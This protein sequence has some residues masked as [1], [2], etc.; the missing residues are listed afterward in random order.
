[1]KCVINLTFQFFFIYLMI[2]IC[3]TSGE[4]TDMKWQ[5]WMN[6]MET[7]KGTV[8]YCLMLAI[9]FVGTRMRV[10]LITNNKGAPQGWVQDGM[11]MATWAVLSQ[12]LFG[13]LV[14][15]CIGTATPCDEDGAPQ[16][17]PS[18]PIAV[19]GVLPI[20]CWD[21]HVS[22]RFG[23]SVEAILVLIRGGADI[24]HRTSRAEL[25]TDAGV[26]YRGDVSMDLGRHVGRRLAFLRL[27]HVE[28]TDETDKDVINQVVRDNGGF[29]KMNV[30]V[31][32]K[33]REAL[34]THACRLAICSPHACDLV[35]TR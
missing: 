18:H 4:F 11:Y 30:F 16:Y 10:L 29:P 31:Q 23:N 6:T 7:M 9:L 14:P 5:L 24:R 3:V 12:F 2:W 19:Y 8:A 25:C 26:M 21:G 20:S 27:E 17:T 22:G 15:L 13:L 1:M 35:D 32:N 34:S 28:A 33:V